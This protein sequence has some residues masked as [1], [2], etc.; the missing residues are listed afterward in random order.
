MERTK[1]KLAVIFLLVVMNLLL[2]GNAV[3][4]HRQN[5]RYTRE[6]VTEAM[7]YLEGHGISVGREDI[8]WTSRLPADPEKISSSE[9]IVFPGDTMQEGETF[10]VGS[11]RRAETLAVDLAN[12]LT[13]L[14]VTELTVDSVAEG[15]RYDGVTRTMVPVWQ[16][17]TDRG[18]FYLNCT[19]GTLTAE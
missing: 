6:A 9:G 15:Y 7:V 14:G 4:Q 5:V 2:L 3:V 1:L 8:P 10:L 11:S 17:K 12:D 13:A 18:D 16:V 19:D